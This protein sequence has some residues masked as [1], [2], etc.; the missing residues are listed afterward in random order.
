MSRMMY[1]ALLALMSQNDNDALGSLPG[2][3]RICMLEYVLGLN[4]TPRI[5]KLQ[6]LTLNPEP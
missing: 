2:G 4:S 3:I 5:F 1:L 6:T